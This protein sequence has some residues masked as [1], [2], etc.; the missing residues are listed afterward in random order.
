MLTSLAATQFDQNARDAA[1]ASLD[2]LKV[3]LEDALYVEQYRADLSRDAQRLVNRVRPDW[4]PDPAARDRLE[5]LKRDCTPE[6]TDNLDALTRREEA[7]ARLKVIWERRRAPEFD[8]LWAHAGSI[9]DFFRQADRAAL[10]RLKEAAKTGSLRVHAPA[11]GQAFHDLRFHVTSGQLELDKTQLFK[12]GLSWVWEWTFTPQPAAN[13]PAARQWLVMGWLF[14]LRDKVGGTPAAVRRQETTQGPC[15][16][17]FAPGP[18]TLRGKV[19]IRCEDQDIVLD[20][21]E[22]AVGEAREFGLLRGFE[23]IEVWSTVWHWGWRWSAAW[24]RGFSTCPPSA[25]RRIT[26]PCSCGVRGV[27]QAKNAW[28]T[29]STYSSAPPRP[30]SSG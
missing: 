27:D 15:L 22:V 1:L 16:V 5:S 2:A 30:G 25:R 6:Q 21:P 9:E 18:G 8:A 3:W 7:Y 26:S 17:Q 12:R 11:E 29:F 20:C 19:R 13:R 28:Q 23:E 10:T 4:I 14:S 24:R